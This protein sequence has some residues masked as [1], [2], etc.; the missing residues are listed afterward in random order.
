MSTWISIEQYKLLKRPYPSVQKYFWTPWLRTP[1]SNSS[2]EGECGRNLVKLHIGVI[3]YSNYQEAYQEVNRKCNGDQPEHQSSSLFLS[4]N[5]MAISAKTKPFWTTNSL[6]ANDSLVESI[7]AVIEPIQVLV[8]S[9]D[10]GPNS[11]KHI[12][13]QQGLAH[14][15]YLFSWHSSTCSDAERMVESRPRFEIKNNI[16]I[17]Y[18]LLWK[19]TAFLL[20]V[21]SKKSPCMHVFCV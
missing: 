19:T 10:F 9:K 21:M 5:G 11:L 2:T 20:H 17:L 15:H 7:A 4:E 6:F 3:L 12:A 8:F 16:C 13:V 14:N 18:I 1:L